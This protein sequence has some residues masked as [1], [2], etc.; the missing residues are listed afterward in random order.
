MA[1]LTNGADTELAAFHHTVVNME[2]ESPC[3]S[4]FCLDVLSSTERVRKNNSVGTE[5]DTENCIT[6]KRVY[7]SSKQDRMHLPQGF[8]EISSVTSKCKQNTLSIGE[9][10][11]TSNQAVHFGIPE[12]FPY[13][14]L[15]QTSIDPSHRRKRKSMEVFNINQQ[16]NISYNAVDEQPNCG[17]SDAE[18]VDYFNKE[19]DSSNIYDDES[20]TFLDRSWG[21]SKFASQQ[22]VGE[23]TSTLSPSVSRTYSSR[24]G[25]INSEYICG[26]SEDTDNGPF[27]QRGTHPT[28]WQTGVDAT[29]QPVIFQRLGGFAGSGTSQNNHHLIRETEE[30]VSFLELSKKLKAFSCGFPGCTR[31]F[32]KQNNLTEHQ[33]I[34]TGERP[35]VCPW[36]AY[37]KA[38]RRGSERKRH[39]RWH[40]GE[41][42]YQC[43]YCARC[44]SRS[45]HRNEHV[46]KI[47]A[48]VIETIR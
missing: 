10:E 7:Y 40:T 36:K 1:C 14:R 43:P 29:N 22:V 35:F 33:R 39:F 19:T 46:R 3:N 11:D 9:N 17:L 34:H 44:F 32:N 20:T 41:K 38:F 12:K 25:G 15:E 2:S 26:Y 4:V 18:N 27:Y 37:G 6:L 48:L 31:S 8:R 45:D 16:T 28:S 13:P 5:T 23:G 47:H 30:N 21:N 24:I 42:P